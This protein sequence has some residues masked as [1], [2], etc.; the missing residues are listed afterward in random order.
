M[1]SITE[2]AKTSLKVKY[3]G[4][5]YVPWCIVVIPPLGLIFIYGIYI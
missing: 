5:G 3:R 2:I 4:H 1:E